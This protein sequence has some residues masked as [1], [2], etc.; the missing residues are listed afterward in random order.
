[1]EEVVVRMPPPRL[2]PNLKVPEA[3]EPTILISIPGDSRVSPEKTP[4]KH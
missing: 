3:K 2:S 4:W 1:M